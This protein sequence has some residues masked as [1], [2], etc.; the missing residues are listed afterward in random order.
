MQG[1]VNSSLNNLMKLE[2][3]H[4]NECLYLPSLGLLRNLQFLKIEE[5]REVKSIGS[6]FYVDQSN[7]DDGVGSA[8][9]F[10][11]LREFSVEYMN[12]LEEWVELE[13][14]TVF[15]CRKLIIDKCRKL[16]GLGSCTSLQHLEIKDCNNII[17]TAEDIGELHS[18]RELQVCYCE[19]LRSIPEECVGRLT[20]LKRLSLG[21][22]WSELE[23]FPGLTS[24]HQLHASLE[25]LVLIG[26]D[27]LKSLPHQLQHLTALKE[28]KLWNFSGLEALPEWLGELSC[29]HNLRICDCSNLTHLP[30]IE[31]VRRLSNLQSLDILFCPKLQ[32]RCAKESGPEWAKI[33]HIPNIGINF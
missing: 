6:K 3:Y 16:F 9:Q 25:E 10:P 30:S 11:A 18:L 24:I 8:T 19:K 14:V 13:G 32:G 2:L 22:F 1:G 26:W 20:C 28:L 17:S 15:P 31:A 12:R 23:E 4:C 33:S 7:S 5:I 27:K 29:L 21:G